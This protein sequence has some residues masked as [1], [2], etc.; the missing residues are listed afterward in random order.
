MG[1]DRARHAAGRAGLAAGAAAGDH[2]YRRAAP[3]RDRRHRHAAD[4]ARGGSIGQHRR[5]GRL[6]A[7]P[8]RGAGPAVRA[9]ERAGRRGRT[10]LRPHHHQLLPRLVQRRTV[11]RR[12]ARGCSPACWCCR[13]DDPSGR[14]VQPVAG[15]ALSPATL[16]SFLP[17]TREGRGRSVDPR[18][19]R[20]RRARR[21]TPPVMD[22]PVGAVGRDRLSHLDQRGRRGAVERPVHGHPGRLHRPRL[23]HPGLLLA[24]DRRCTTDRRPHRR[25]HRTAAVPAALGRFRRAR[26][27][28]G[29]VG[30]HRAGR[31][32]RLRLR[33]HRQRLHRAHR[34]DPGRQPAR[35][36][37]RE[38]RGA[39]QP[40]G[41]AR[42]SARARP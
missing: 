37:Q 5:D 23:A 26:A 18:R 7:G 28:P 2:P 36:A 14:C 20:H 32:D 19:T 34:D 9:D 10:R 8:R 6:F 3:G 33:G 22:A 1:A 16:R 13:P 42:L 27:G 40:G 35:R 15:C 38:G 21:G 12:A 25:T 39:D 4:H 31:A 29:A 24:L 41:V 30:R 11:R 17:D